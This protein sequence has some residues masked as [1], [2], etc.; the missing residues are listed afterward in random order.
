MTMMLTRGHATIHQP[1]EIMKC[2]AIAMI[3]GL[4]M[5]TPVSA[6]QSGV[7][8]EVVLTRDGKVIASPI[9]LGEFGKAVTIEQGGTM[10]VEAVAGPPDK[11]GHS[12]TSVKFQIFENGRLQPPQES[13]LLADLGKTSSIEFA[14]PGT[15]ARF[16]FRQALVKLPAGKQG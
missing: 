3:L 8:Y 1:G 11:N 14:V 12:L 4:A 15:N 13:S 9:F 2:A 10:R 5:S 6:D 16:T 7:K